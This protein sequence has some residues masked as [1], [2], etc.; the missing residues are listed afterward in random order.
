MN[1]AILGLSH[2]ID[3]EVKRRESKIKGLGHL[4]LTGEYQGRSGATRPAAPRSSSRTRR[5]TRCAMTLTWRKPG[6]STGPSPPRRQLPA[7]SAVSTGNSPRLVRNGRLATPSPMPTRARPPPGHRG[8]R[9]HWPRRLPHAQEEVDR[10]LFE[11]QVAAGQGC[12]GGPAPFRRRRDDAGD[13]DGTDGDSN[14]AG[15]AGRPSATS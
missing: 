10:L 15:Q 4:R 12:P 5:W 8:R 1:C 13:D 14:A 11:R 6:L 9:Q 2:R 7:A 3:V